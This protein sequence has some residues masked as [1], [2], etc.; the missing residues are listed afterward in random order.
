[1]GIAAIASY[2]SFLKFVF[3]SAVIT[4]E[5]FFG[6]RDSFSNIGGKVKSRNAGGSVGTMIGDE[7]TD[8]S[9]QSGPW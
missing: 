3:T 5:A 1:M 7:E 6:G 4:V 8:K 9:I 2:S